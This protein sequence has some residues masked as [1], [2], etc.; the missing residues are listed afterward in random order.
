MAAKCPHC[1]KMWDIDPK[2]YGREVICTKCKNTF[3]AK[4]YDPDLSDDEN[5]QIDPP[6]G[7]LRMCCRIGGGI[8]FGITAWQIYEIHAINGSKFNAGDNWQLLLC[9]GLAGFAFLFSFTEPPEGYVPI[10]CPN[11]NCNYRG[12]A[13]AKGGPNG[14]VF[15]LLL[16]LGIL[17][18]LIYYLICGKE[19]RVICPKC[20][21]KI[22]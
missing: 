20:G 11:Q 14:C 21:V 8:V 12:L 10:I 18:A 19:K 13:R 22:R 16:L 6:L 1:E 9:L 7:A 17:P 15:F 2:Y 4:Q 5:V 3:V